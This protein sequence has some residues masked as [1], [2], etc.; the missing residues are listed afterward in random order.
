MLVLV[1]D[2]LVEHN[3]GKGILFKIPDQILFI[4]QMIAFRIRAVAEI[5]KISKG[6]VMELELVVVLSGQSIV[7]AAGIPSPGNALFTEAVPDG[8]K[9]LGR[10]QTAGISL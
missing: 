2:R 7:P 1:A 4:L 8:W 10:Q 6:L 3:G 9:R 5:P